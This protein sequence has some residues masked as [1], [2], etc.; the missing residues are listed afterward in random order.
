MKDKLTDEIRKVLDDYLENEP[1]ALFGDIMGG[2]SAREKSRRRGMWLSLSGVAA[3]VAALLMALM[4]VP[5]E[6]EPYSGQQLAELES[7]QVGSASGSS[8]T[9][10]ADL[11]VSGTV[12][13]PAAD[14]ASPV[15]IRTAKKAHSAVEGTAAG[16]SESGSVPEEVSGTEPAGP[17]EDEPEVRRVI[18]PENLPEDTDEDSGI[19]TMDWDPDE[20]EQPQAYIG[21]L[22]LS[23]SG[24]NVLSSS[25]SGRITSVVY[26]ASAS[27]ANSFVDAVHGSYS[28]LG[29]GAED[30]KALLSTAESRYAA[31]LND[32]CWV[33]HQPVRIG[34]DAAWKFH[35]RWTLSG[36]VTYSWLN[37][38]FSGYQGGRQISLKQTL[39]YV[40]IPVSLDFSLWGDERW[41]VYLLAGG[42][43]EKCVAGSVSGGDSPYEVAENELQWSVNAGAG[44]Q[45]SLGRLFGLYL[46]PGAAWYFENG[47]DVENIY[48]DRP[49]NFNLRFGLRYTFR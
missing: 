33:H 26:D 32:I 12:G 17:A 16:Q 8:V 19:R 21:R 47:S 39:H 37:S 46:E 10:L 42:L 3:A 24:M 2:L 28:S 43:A 18:I 6:K 41:N 22:A 27:G 44:V 4:Y 34:I 35:G 20:E 45:F 38:S 49:F 1:D 14:G 25:N 29:E 5:G 9:A 48:K 13:P 40:G 30:T 31:N 36:G 15:I 23:L 7:G 11:T